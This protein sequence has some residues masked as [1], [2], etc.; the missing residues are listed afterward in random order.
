MSLHTGPEFFHVS[1]NADA[2]PARLTP[3]PTMP[4]LDA[5]RLAGWHVDDRWTNDLCPNHR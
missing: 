1:C 4:I 3:K 5:A 2:C